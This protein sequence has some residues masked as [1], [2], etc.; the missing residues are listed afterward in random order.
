MNR[1]RRVLELF[2]QALAVRA[3]DREAFLSRECGDDARLRYSVEALLWTRQDATQLFPSDEAATSVSRDQSAKVPPRHRLESGQM[4]LGRYEIVET[5]GAG[6]MGEVYR[7]RDGR[8]DRQVAVKVLNLASLHD[9]QMHARFDREAK[10]VAALSHPNIM[11]LYDVA[12]HD[13]VQ[14]AVMELVEG[15]TLRK[16]IDQGLDWA[17]AVRLARGIAAGL[18]AAHAQDIMHRDIKPENVMVT[19]LGQAKILDFGLARQETVDVGLTGGSLVPGTV[20]Y[21]SPEQVE[22]RALTC[23]T[24]IFSLGTVLYE[25]VTGINPFRGATTVETMTN[26]A[27]AAPANIHDVAR[28]L[29]QVLTDIIQAM[30]H[31]SADQRPSAKEVVYRLEQFRPERSVTTAVRAAGELESTTKTFAD[32]HVTGGQPTI[33]VLPLQ[34]RAADPNHQLYGDAV[35]SEIIVE[36]SKLR[37][38]FVIARGSSFQFRD[39]SVDL[40]AA[41]RVLGARYFLTGSIHVHG[42]QAI[43]TA[44][45]SQAAEGRVVW[46]DRF[47][48]AIGDVLQLRYTITARIVTAIETRIQMAEAEQA[49]RLPTENLDAWSAYHRGIWHMYRFNQHDNQIATQMFQRAISADP[50][51]ARAHAG[52]SFTHFQDA[53]L[54][55]SNDAAHQRELTRR[56]A[57]KSLELD[58]LD[59]FVNL[60]MGRSAWLDNHLESSADWLDRTLDLSP[61]Y[62]F[63]V[64]NRGLIDAILNDGEQSERRIERAIALSPIDPLNHAMC[65][66]RALSHIVRGNYQEAVGWA[67]QAAKHPTAHAHL[68]LI[69]ALANELV[70]DRDAASQF[71]NRVRQFDANYTADDFFQ[72]FQF[73][74]EATRDAIRGALH[75][76]ATS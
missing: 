67:N 32:H 8:L 46:A 73:R 37:W 27:D 35:A 66:T 1:E 29:P 31:R 41:S 19:K 28:H 16:F 9:E 4:L 7:A 56:L 50:H 68:F 48:C 10:S 30:M 36:L 20:P 69:G 18:E 55:Y 5:I 62:A 47:D 40:T 59:P 63:A 53:F 2:E 25:M 21:M 23:A 75:R 43:V 70:G 42:Q 3:E 51:F 45:L 64:Y 15:Q 11:T 26:V 57:E 74:D 39:A 44:E 54:D 76:L 61:N 65:G 17:E 33:A 71:W 34:I 22:N 14:F 72:S 12:A 52:L 38:L 60:T 6:G 49:A 58:P 24:D 13:D